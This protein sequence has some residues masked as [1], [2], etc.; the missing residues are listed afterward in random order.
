MVGALLLFLADLWASWIAWAGGILRIIPFCEGL[1]EPSLRSKFPRVDSWFSAHGVA[2]KKNLRLI[3]MICLFI[4]CYRAWVFE[5]R[6]AQNAMYGKD[7]KS[8]AWSKFNTCD[9]DRSNLRNLSSTYS[10]QLENQRNFINSQQGTINTCVVSLAKLNQS[11]PLKI[12]PFYLGVLEGSKQPTVAPFS[13]NFLL[14]TNKI[15]TPVRLL[16][17]CEPGLLQAGGGILG[18]AAMTGGGWGGRFSVKQFGVGFS[19]P[20]WTPASPMIVTV[21]SNEKELKCSFVEQ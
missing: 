15:I 6:N 7:G 21:Y 16:V 12:T 9:A 11:A 14:L 10:I 8:E 5:H 20:A 19:S 17:T 18:T 3:G 4:G 2:L 13:A 1:I